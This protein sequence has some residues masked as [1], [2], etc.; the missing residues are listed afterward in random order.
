M[1]R[2]VETR[3]DIELLVKE[4]IVENRF[5][6]TRGS[7]F[8]NKLADGAVLDEDNFYF[9]SLSKDLN[10]Y[11]KTR[12]HKRKT[13]LRQKY[14]KTPWAVIWIVA[15]IFLSILIIIQ[16]VCSVIQSVKGN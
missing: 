7:D 1:N 14:F 4:G 2:L 10:A 9:A 3:K 16:T 12:W 8:L 5:N 13:N 11:Y 15:A 6:N